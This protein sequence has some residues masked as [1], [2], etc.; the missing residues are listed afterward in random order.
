MT[1][2]SALVGIGLCAAIAGCFP[3]EET[4]VLE[5]GKPARI[6]CTFSLNEVQINRARELGLPV[7]VDAAGKY[8]QDRGYRLVPK[9]F[10]QEEMTGE[11]AGFKKLVLKFE[12]MDRASRSPVN[13]LIY[14]R[15]QSG[16]NQYTFSYDASIRTAD[17]NALKLPPQEVDQI[18]YGDYVLKVQ[19]QGKVLAH[20]GVSESVSATSTTITW[21]HKIRDLL[22]E[23]AV[24][25]TARVLILKES[26]PGGVAWLIAGGAA[27]GLLLGLV[28]AYLQIRK[29]TTQDGRRGKA[30]RKRGHITR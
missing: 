7:S 8:V 10:V 19:F 6:T 3:V 27:I 9:G 4:I 17:G 15:A 14:Q 26:N 12:A 11:G 18:G 28:Q 13:G 21:R 16:S 2:I 1:R 29:T 30:T 25:C 22:S 24:P 20:S 5:E 23:N